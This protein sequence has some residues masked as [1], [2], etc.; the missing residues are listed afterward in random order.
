M[1]LLPF[2]EWCEATALGQ[3][4]RESLWLF[5]VIESVHL[6]ALATLGGAVLVVDMRSLGIGLGGNRLADIAR[7]A[8][9]W[10]VGS[11]VV[12]IATGVPLFMSE[13]IRCYYSP[14]FWWKMQFLAVAIVYTFTVR[15]KVAR[16]DPERVGPLW[17]KLVGLVSLAL[18]F[19]VAFSGRWISFY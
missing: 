1:T 9:P 4:I 10:L 7:D 18:W 19:G 13:S 16:A 17:G 11:L 8:H 14:P 12:M 2:F 5:P 15:R 3:T 6:L